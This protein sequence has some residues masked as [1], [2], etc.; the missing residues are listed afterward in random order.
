VATIS[1][2]RRGK[3]LKLDLKTEDKDFVSWIEGNA[4]RLINELH[5]RWKRSE[6]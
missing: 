6:D 5:E 1:T 3:Q 4:P 2:G